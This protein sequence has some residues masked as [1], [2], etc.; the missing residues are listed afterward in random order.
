MKVKRLEIRKMP[1]FPHGLKTELYQ[2]LADQINIIAGANGTGK[3]STARV[4]QRLIWWDPKARL[5]AT[6]ELLIANRPHQIRIQSPDYRHIDP[7]GNTGSNDFKTFVSE[8]F[9]KQYILALHDLVK[10]DDNELAKDLIKEINGGFDLD[11]AAANL[12]YNERTYSANQKKYVDYNTANQMLSST[13][14]KQEALKIE[15]RQLE[16]LNADLE[17]AGEARTLQAYYT[18]VTEW[19][20]L[21]EKSK[22]QKAHLYS[23]PKKLEQLQPGDWPHIQKLE[24]KINTYNKEIDLLEPQKKEAEAELEKIT[25]LQPKEEEAV[26]KRIQSYRDG[27]EEKKRKADD[28]QIEIVRKEK[29]RTH[30]AA[31]VGLTDDQATGNLRLEEINEIDLFVRQANQAEAIWRELTDQK[32]RLEDELKEK[33]SP[34]ASLPPDTDTLYKGIAELSKWLKAESSSTTTHTKQ[35]IGWLAAVG[36]ITSLAVLFWDWV[37]LLPGI[38][39]LLIW[40]IYNQQNLKKEK[41]ILLST[42]I[43]AYNQLGLEPLSAWES[44]QVAERLQGLITQ[45]QDVNRLNALKSQ[46]KELTRKQE[47]IKNEIADKQERYKELMQRFCLSTESLRWQEESYNTLYYFMQKLGEWQKADAELQSGKRALEEI[48]SQYDALLH[49]GNEAFRLLG[50]QPVHTFEDFKAQSMF[51]AEQINR[52]KEF[53]NQIKHTQEKIDQYREL[54]KESESELQTIYER[55]GTTEK[56]EIRL[57]TGELEAYEKAKKAYAETDTILREKQQEVSKFDIKGGKNPDEFTLEEATALQKQYKSEAEQYD[58][59]LQQITSIQTHVDNAEKGNSLEEAIVQKEK[60]LKELEEVFESNLQSI[61]GALIVNQLKQEISLNNENKVFCEANRILGEITREQYALTLNYGKEAGFKAKD[62]VRDTILDLEQL[63][64]GTRVQLLLAIRL[65]YIQSLEKQIKLPILADELLANSDDQRSEAIIRSLIAISKERQVFYFTAQ[66]DEVN[67]WNHFL[68][69][70]PEQAYKIILLDEESRQRGVHRPQVS[71][72][73][74]NEQVPEPGKLSHA[75]Y[76]ELLAFQPF[77]L[78]ESQET[79]LHLWYLFDNPAQLYPFLQRGISRWGQLRQ[80]R[81]KGDS[82]NLTDEAW[83]KIEQKIQLL[84]FYC[85]RYR[86]GRPSMIDQTVLEASGAISK[87]Y[88]PVVAEALEAHGGNPLALLEVLEKDI[89]GFRTKKIDDLREYL[90]AHKYYDGKEQLKKEEIEIDLHV[91]A[92]SLGMDLQAADQFIKQL[93]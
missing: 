50:V 29:A 88:M 65:A 67:K 41:N 85:E 66:M 9:D 24:E 77:N 39:L 51:T 33:E 15:Q 48:R 76:K 58:V 92:S 1:G 71:P 42:A 63:S 11:G 90:I 72:R 25:L 4:I 19:L 69:Q 46:H 60:A 17:K 13:R 84:Q 6:A 57:L 83:Q 36:G 79:E 30:A 74:W 26:I 68:Q 37:G 43:S 31:V 27:L 53:G 80:L 44:K 21:K 64:T 38:I 91:R 59:L 8:N 12:G 35:W 10:G 40:Q 73:L 52:R 7:Q 18:K 32:E 22:E 62:L 5:N 70:E 34:Y 3:S 82:C 2:D 75:G 20:K 61:S 16:K 54:R 89:P 56:E 87:T 93:L 47:R 45:V 28:L 55:L 49:T 78:S 23:F 86:I 14:K 81:E